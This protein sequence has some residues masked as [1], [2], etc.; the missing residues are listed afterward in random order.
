M[1]YKKHLILSLSLGDG[2]I[3]G[4]RLSI[5]HCEKQKDLLLWKQNLLNSNGF[6]TTFK[7][8]NNN[9]YTGYLLYTKRDNFIGK[10][11]KELYTPNKSFKCFKNNLTLEDLAILYMDDGSVSSTK[12][13]AILTIST[14]TT[15][16]ENQI[17]IDT[18]KL[19]FGVSFGQRKMKNHYALVC[20][21]KEA[22]KFIQLVSPIVSQVKCMHYKLK[23]KDEDY[24]IHN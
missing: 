2:C 6:Y 19:N 5:V 10:L 16:E 8:I 14:C 7:K 9:N 24:V 1:D 15:K 23:V 12:N 13:R 3:S 20:S 11:R 21:T 17:L 18:I 22:R 4:N